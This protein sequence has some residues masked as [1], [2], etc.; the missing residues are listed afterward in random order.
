METIKKLEFKKVDGTAVEDVERYVKDWIRANPFGKIIVA[1][2]SQIHGRRVKY[3]VIIVMHY[4]D[5]ME[6]GHGA[7]VILA[8]VWERRVA[9][10]PIE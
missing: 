4:V 2:D 9:R 3:S 7:H 10:T 8:D 1:C 6:V 5:V